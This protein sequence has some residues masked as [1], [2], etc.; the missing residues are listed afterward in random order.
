MNQA[1]AGRWGT[2]MSRNHSLTCLL[3]RGKQEVGKAGQG[4]WM[5]LGDG[6][7][8]VW[9]GRSLS[10][11][12]PNPG[13]AVQAGGSLRGYGRMSDMDMDKAGLVPD[14]LCYYCTF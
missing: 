2:W 4:V 11:T 3:M 13:L 6:T 7:T 1:M 5:R 10:V 14:E 12:H 9:G 8:R